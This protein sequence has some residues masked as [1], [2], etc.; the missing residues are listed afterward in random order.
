MTEWGLTGCCDTADIVFIVLAILYP[1]IINFLWTTP[2]IFPFKLLTV[3]LH[4]MGHATAVKHT[5]KYSATFFC[6]FLF[7]NEAW[8][9]CG[10]VLEIDVNGDL[11]GYTSHFRRLQLRF[12]CFYFVFWG[13]VCLLSVSGTKHGMFLN[14]A[15]LHPKQ[16]F[17][18]KII[19]F[20]KLQLSET[21]DFSKQ[22]LFN[23]LG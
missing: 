13:R 8:L 20:L 3:F 21:T 2:V 9:T 6:L 15:R 4:E 5:K 16:S 1:I 19:A 10:R 18:T 12:F 17:V 7:C 14:T 22:Q 23:F 11:G